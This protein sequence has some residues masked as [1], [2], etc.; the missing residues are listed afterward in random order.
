MCIPGLNSQL[1]AQT[2]TNRDKYNFSIKFVKLLTNVWNG[3][4]CDIEKL[5]RFRDQKCGAESSLR[6]V[7][8]ASG[9]QHPKLL[10]H[11]STLASQFDLLLD[12]Q[13]QHPTNLYQ[14][15]LYIPGD[16]NDIQTFS[17]IGNKPNN[18]FFLL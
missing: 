4:S 12:D 5:P 3:A 15:V 1:N 18:Y 6:R 17:Y 7:V 8:P 16:T 9:K 13:V 14:C 2:F 11:N 10:G